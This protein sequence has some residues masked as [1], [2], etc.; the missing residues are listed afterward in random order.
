MTTDR[1][2]LT[3]R[4]LVAGAL[5]LAWAMPLMAEVPLAQVGRGKAPTIDGRL[6]EPAWRTCGRFLPFIAMNRAGLAATQTQALAF[7]DAAALYI[8]FR[9]DEPAMGRLVAHN[10]THDGALWHDDCVEVLLR[11]PGGAGLAHFIVNTI[12]VTYEAKD[13]ERSWN[14]SFRAAVHKGKES[15]SAEMAIPWKALG[16]MPEP[17]DTWRMNFCRER[18]AVTELSSWSPASGRFVAP[19]TFGRVAFVD[20]AI[21]VEHFDPGEQLPGANRATLLLAGQ[22]E[23]PI[24]V[25]VEGVK[26]VGVAAGAAKPVELVYALGLGGKELVFSAFRQEDPVWRSVIPTKIEPAPQ[27]GALTDLIGGVRGMIASIPKGHALTEALGRTLREAEKAASVFREA[28]DASLAAGKPLDMKRYRAINQRAAGEVTRLSM[29]R[30]P[31]WTKNNWADLKR[32]EL[33]EEIEDVAQLEVRSLVNEYESANVIVTNLSTNAL[34]LRVTAPGLTWLPPVGESA[35][36]AVSNGDF[37]RHSREGRPPDGWRRATGK[38]R[39]WQVVDDPQRGK[40][41][42]VRSGELD[43]LTLRQELDL[44]VGAT[45]VL[46]YWARSENATPSV[47]VGVINSGWTRAQFSRPV[48]GTSGWHRVTRTVSVRESELHQLV[49]WAQGGGGQVWIDDVR[50][51]EGDDPVIAFPEARPRLAV[52]DWQELRIGTVVADPLIP[53]NPAGRLDVPPGESRQVWLTLPARDLPP[54]RYETNLLLRPLAT[55]AHNGSPPAKSVRIQLRVDPL[56]VATYPDFAVYNWDYARNEAYVRDLAEHKVTFFLVSTHMPKPEFDDQGN[57]LG[58]IDYSD[59]DRLLRLKMR[60]ARRTG[61][62]LLF[63]Y[64][65]IRGFWRYANRKGW[66]FLSEPWVRAFRHTYTRWLEHLKALGLDYDDF[67]V[68]TWDEATGENVD[69]VVEG[70]KLLREI[71]PKVRLVM[72]GAQSIEEVRRMDPYIDVWVPHLHTLKRPKVGP[73]LLEVYRGLGEPVYTYTCSTNM[74]SLS[75]YTYHRLKPWEAANLRLEGVFYWDYNSWRGDPWND[76]D[77]PI[78]DCGAVYDGVDGPIT[79]RRWEASREGIEDWQIMRLLERLAGGDEARAQA[80][81]QFVDETIDHVLGNKDDRDLADASRIKLIAAALAAAK[82][83]PLLIQDAA[84]EQTGRELTVRF[85]TNRPA[86]GV[87]WYRPEGM[88]RWSR[89]SLS[90]ERSHAAAITLPPMVGSDWIVIAWD[91]AGRVAT[92]VGSSE[93]PGR[94]GRA[95]AR[96]RIYADCGRNV[97]KLVRGWIDVKRDPKTHLYSRGKVW[98]YHNEAADQ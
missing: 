24:E 56:R 67:C 74:K 19:A 16:G 52:A 37:E 72:D 53:L 31:V 29:L 39:G 36:N 22:S 30:W 4:R 34:R 48:S 55:R 3:R 85:E 10:K 49:I 66:D 69:Y 11:L 82:A 2:L 12:G 83:D 90:R 58:E 60:Y 13:H 94:W 47:R 32:D 35:P 84:S 33:P 44:K 38:N 80:A 73:K 62:E 9:C 8:G 71:D 78:A 1:T 43:A 41:L 15:W 5:T 54:G 97:A 64:G 76:F 59:Y 25:R 61:G 92:A 98:D 6:D 17:G 88:Q 95:R 18:R 77:G 40:V 46:S 87:L 28:I 21:R 65:I 63:S 45:Y 70:G 7:Y 86:Q 75:P 89:A 79:S 23:A 14:P 91:A 20:R 68:Q 96:G 50:L 93:S 81:R 51:L 42:T 27:L 26:P 57:A